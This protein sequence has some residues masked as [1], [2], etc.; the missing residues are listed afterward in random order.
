MPKEKREI[1][2]QDIMSLDLYSKQRKVLRKNIVEYKKIIE[3]CQ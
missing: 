1:H 2:K 3:K